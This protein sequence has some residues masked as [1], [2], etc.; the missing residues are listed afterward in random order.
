MQIKTTIEERAKHAFTKGRNTGIRKIEN[1]KNKKINEIN[2]QPNWIENT[3]NTE[4]PDFLKRVLLLGPNFNIQSKHNIPYVKF[5]ADVES[6]IA[7]KPEAEDIRADVATAISNHLNYQRQPRSKETEWIKRDIVSSRAFLKTHEDIYIT[8]A[9]KGNKTVILSAQEYRQK[10]SLL[11]SDATTY[12]QMNC[13]PTSKILKQLNTIVE[14]WHQDQH[15]DYFTKTKLQ[16][17]HCHP[18]RIYGLPKIHKPERPLRPVVSTIGSATYSVA[19]YLT[20]ILNNI[21]GKTEYHV[22]NSFVFAEDI[23][24]VRIP[25]GCVMFS[26]DVVSLY[27]NVPAENAYAFIEDQWHRL[28]KYTTLSLASLQ[29]A[30]SVV[31][32]SSFFKYN[33]NYYKQI[34]GVPMGSSIS[35][36]IASICMEKLEQ[37]CIELARESDVDVIL[38]EFNNAHKTLKFTLEKEEQ[39]TIRFLD[40]T[41]S[42]QHDKIIKT[43]FTKQPDGRYL[44]FNS[45]SPF[46][47]K[48]N[49]IC[50]K[51]YIGQT[52][53]TLEKRTKQHEISIRVKNKQ[54]GLAQHALEDDAYHTFDFTKT[55]ILE[56]ISHKSH[57]LIAEK[58]HIKLRG[59]QAVNLQIDTKGV[60]NAYNGLWTKLREERERENPKTLINRRPDDNQQQQQQ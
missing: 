11:V 35:G 33:N 15:I 32:K 55:Q 9:D 5:V 29:Q 59:N 8:R 1:L 30:L 39:Q 3:T 56:M 57:R 16:T 14:K 54:T 20:D 7:K 43:W 13:D 25:E 36:C 47:H 12:Q 17:F 46:T 24:K 31:L 10:M 27:T 2:Q 18:P 60:S 51:E 19:R 48:Q 34:H 42:R 4:I 45:E 50:G 53:Q 26:L 58:L 41:L 23:S 6:A 44:D 49:T 21:V 28:R 40:M 38:E 52:S 37:G 22:K